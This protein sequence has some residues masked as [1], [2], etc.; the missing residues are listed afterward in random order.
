MTSVASQAETGKKRA[1]SVPRA[2]K[3]AATAAIARA[4][5]TMTRM[6]VAVFFNLL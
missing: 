1:R 3:T 4:I 2:S 6:V 5:T